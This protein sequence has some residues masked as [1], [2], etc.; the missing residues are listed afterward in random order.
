VPLNAPVFSFYYYDVGEADFL[1]I[2]TI[3]S[4]NSIPVAL[5]SFLSLVNKNY[6]A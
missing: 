6:T 2:E 3:L 4:R 5:L 1:E